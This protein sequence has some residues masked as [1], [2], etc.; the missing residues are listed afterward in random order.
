[1]PSA[2][3]ELDRWQI[4]KKIKIYLDIIIEGPLKLTKS[5]Q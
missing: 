4:I 2:I 1:M 5:Q 3:R